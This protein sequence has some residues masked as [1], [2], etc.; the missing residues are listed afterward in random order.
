M[1]NSSKS[2]L[3][4]DGTQS[5]A[6][7][8]DAFSSLSSDDQPIYLDD[9]EARQQE[10]DQ[11]RQERESE[12]KIPTE[13]VAETPKR[14]RGRPRKMKP[15][16]PKTPST[17]ESAVA[18]FSPTTEANSPAENE[19][20]MTKTSGEM[21]RNS[22]NNGRR[23]NGQSEGISHST[24]NNNPRRN[25]SAFD[26]SNANN[27]PRKPEIRSNNPRN[28]TVKN[29]TNGP[30]LPFG[31]LR[32]WEKI[33]TFQSAETLAIE[34]FGDNSPFNFNEVYELP[35]KALAELADSMEFQVQNGNSQRK[36]IL[37]ACLQ[38]S[39]QNR[40]PILISGILELLPDGNGYLIYGHDN[41]ALSE[42]SAFIPRA[43]IK[44]WGVRRGQYLTI[45]CCIS[46][47][48]VT[49]PCALKITAVMGKD[50]S[51]AAAMPNFKDL[52]PYYPRQRIIL[53]NADVSTAYNLSMRIVDLL[54]PI[55]L[56]QRGLI[57]APPRTGKTML[58]QAI[59]NA[60]HRNRPDVHLMVLLI[61]ERPEEVTDFRR[62]AQGEVYAST[63][64]E[65]ADNHIHLAEMVIET[66]RRRVENGE[67]VIILLDSITRLARAYNAVMPTSGRVLSGG[68]D[69][70]ALQGPKSFFGSARNIE[71]G[72]SLT[73]LGTALVE[74]GSRMD[75]VIF[76]EFKGTGNME[77][78]LDRELAEKR[79]FPAINVSK[80]G[81]RKEELLYHPDEL[82][83][84][85][86]IRR[87]MGGIA[88]ADAMDMLLQR[89]KKT[90]SNAEFL[91]SVNR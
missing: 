73:I 18:N 47:E 75:D 90:A 27:N 51:E 76:E 60:I 3:S 38:Q 72:G 42:M 69:A 56:G 29:A 39:A 82:A 87:A 89:M 65:L 32:E 57:V 78:N 9:I 91:M 37:L 17:E 77:L 28:R 36:Q 6:E 81:T 23:G 83:R 68:I 8:G 52:I 46:E 22:R 59:A 21:K 71:G 13:T 10:R 12:A 43:L 54:T 20:E 19:G 7:N 62:M 45:H 31:N 55:G 16:T 40:I 1:E 66:A 61:D 30:R 4:F 70:N 48:N 2:F 24:R 67:H 15:E 49:V 86:I 41:Y 44:E 35:L 50:P 79:I 53:E 5:T 34:A 85:Y 11:R 74:T 63:F 25:A 14:P 58:L 33:R 88:P 80:S 64:D 84:V 26:H